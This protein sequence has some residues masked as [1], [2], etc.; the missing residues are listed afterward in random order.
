ME[1][2]CAE[3]IR[4]CALLGNKNPYSIYSRPGAGRH[5]KCHCE[6]LK[7]NDYGG[8]INLDKIPVDDKTMTAREIGTMNL[9]SASS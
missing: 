4:Q 7:D 8:E 6:L 5:R 9:R 2:R 1:R 3:V